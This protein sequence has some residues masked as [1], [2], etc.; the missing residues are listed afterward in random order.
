MS[1]GNS[2]FII[3]KPK[4]CLSQ[5]SKEHEKKTLGDYFDFPKDIYP[6]GRLDEDSEGLLILSNDKSINSLLLNPKNG[7]WR[8]YWALVNGQIHKKAL[9]ELERGVGIFINKKKY[10]TL[11]ARVKKGFP[12]KNIPPLEIEKKHT[13]WLRISVQEG[14]NR[15]VRKMTAKVGFPTLRLIRT[16]IELLDLGDLKPGDFKQMDKKQFF[17]K[18]KI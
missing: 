1:R 16:H 3:Y 11:P 12:P 15:Q 17:S 13:S 18:L 5:F 8:T 10:N 4:G 2:Y 14:K 6:V 9:K 7:H